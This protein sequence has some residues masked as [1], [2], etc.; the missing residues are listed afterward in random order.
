MFLQIYKCFKSFKTE[1]F[2]NII[3]ILAINY[4]LTIIKK[5]LLL[6]SIFASIS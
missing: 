1:A 5:I 4:K 3:S 2:T 6:L